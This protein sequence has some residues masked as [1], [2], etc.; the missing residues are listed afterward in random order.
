M[1]KIAFFMPSFA[2]GGAERVALTLAAAFSSLGHQVD[3]VVTSFEGD[4]I[5]SVP[6]P[7]KIIDLHAHRMMTSIPGLGK[8]LRVKSTG[9]VDCGTG[10]GESDCHLG[11]DT[12]GQSSP[13]PDR[14]SYTTIDVGQDFTEIAGKTLPVSC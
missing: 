7:C 2:G 9:R 3:F 14:K 4:L 8:Y 5:S 12:G 11:K 1:S 6:L 10:Y 13:S